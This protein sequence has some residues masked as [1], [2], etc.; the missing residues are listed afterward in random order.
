MKESARGSLDPTERFTD[1]V[2]DY[3]RA[4]PGYP[5]ELGEALRDV[6]ALPAPG[7]RIADIGCGTGISAAWIL[8]QGYEVVGVEPNAAMRAAAE[9]ALG[10]RS[11]FTIVAGSAE[12]TTLAPSSVKAIFAAQAFHWFE[13]EAT[14]REFAR[15]V[16]GGPVI[17]LW[18]DR[19]TEGSP[20]LVG[21]EALLQRWAVDYNAVNHR[22]IDAPALDAFFRGGRSVD[23]ALTNVQSLTLE[24]LLARVR[25]S[26][27]VPAP[28]DP[29]HSPMM[30]EFA[31]LYQRCQSAGRVDLVY[32]LRVRVGW[33]GSDPPQAE[34][35]RARR[36]DESLKSQRPRGR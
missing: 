2:E 16:G 9:A 28:G 23:L 17:L 1:R 33:F 30:A 4:R 11:G 34:A 29:R 6:G 18:N 26:S 36:F 5:E 13:P 20:L 25:S 10:G 19:R 3:V 21:Y 27:Y 31:A 22:R 12:A 7:A 24:G 14:R 32:D 15:I 8:A 35:P